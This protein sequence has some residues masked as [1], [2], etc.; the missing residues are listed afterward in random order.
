MP[1]DIF[2][3][4][5][6]ERP[7]PPISATR[8]ETW[9]GTT[10]LTLA[11]YDDAE[12]RASCSRAE[13]NGAKVKGA[14][15]AAN[16]LI[17]S[18][19]LATGIHDALDCDWNFAV[20]ASAFFIAGFA[21]LVDHYVFMRSGTF[22]RGMTLIQTGGFTQHVALG[23]WLLT[24]VC[25]GVR[26]TLAVVLGGLEAHVIALHLNAS[27]IDGRVDAEYFARNSVIVEQTVKLN[28][29]DRARLLADETQARSN[30]TV[31]T[32]DHNKAVAAE[33]KES[34]R[35]AGRPNHKVLDDLQAAR[36]K[37]EQALTTAQ[38][39][40]SAASRAREA[41]DAGS[42]ERTSD[43]IEHTPGHIV[44]DRSFNTRVRLLFAELAEHP[45][46]IIPSALIDLFVL[47]LDL[48]VCTIAGIGVPSTYAMLEARR[49][50]KT[51]TELAADVAQQTPRRPP[52]S[53]AAA[54]EPPAP[55]PD[56]PSPQPPRRGP[57][58]PKGSVNK[59]STNGV[60]NV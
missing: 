39:E 40:L 2:A 50:I 13:L 12:L 38:A 60:A 32:E 11:A 10:F 51:M 9:L 22:S 27:A 35:V 6:P 44:R 17:A 59:R 20:F 30:V 41:F 48:V 56:D 25:R 45:A 8:K 5:P 4:T 24:R 1:L 31:R 18:G 58:R 26:I 16:A 53:P 55:R 15:V 42:A 49:T 52:P 28:A 46:N 37:A 7:P 36:T 47:G 14:L 33:T 29:A 43:Q 34:R 3:A 23:S 19:V 21:A 54:D 57:G